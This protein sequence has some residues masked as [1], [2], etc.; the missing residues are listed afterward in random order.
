M[1]DE[2]TTPQEQPERRGS[3]DRRDPGGDARRPDDEA[4]AE[5]VESERAAAGV[6]DYA[7]EDVPEAEDTEGVEDTPTR[8]G[9]ADTAAHR[10]A[11]AEV[12][13]QARS[14]KLDTG[15]DTPPDAERS[16]YPPTRYGER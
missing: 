6:T 12:R 10:E 5:R 4:L 13:R 11:D 2:E 8:S 14:G 1:S 3:R 9:V 16:P 7:R 15:D